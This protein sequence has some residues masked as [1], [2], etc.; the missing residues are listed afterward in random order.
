MFPVLQGFNESY[1]YNEA[2]GRV[3]RTTSRVALRWGGS[4]VVD[5]LRSGPGV[6]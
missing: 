2:G 6:A 4:G 5:E 3:L 1:G